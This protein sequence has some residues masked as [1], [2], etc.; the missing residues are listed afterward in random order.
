MMRSLLWVLCALIPMTIGS[1]EKFLDLDE[2][3]GESEE[4]EKEVC[5]PTLGC[6]DNQPPFDNAGGNVPEDPTLID[7][8]FLLFTKAKAKQPE[9]L[10][11][12]NNDKSIT[13][14]QF[15]N[16]NW[17]RIIVHGFTNN[18]DSSWIPHMIDELLKLKD[19]KICRK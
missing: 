4:E 9:I 19:V 2:L 11:Y 7:T 13:T 15:N 10:Q 12:E 6:F 14:S 5:Y 17:L 1:H 16:S 8:H 3:N 18:R